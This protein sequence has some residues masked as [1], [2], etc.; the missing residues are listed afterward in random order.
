MNAPPSRELFRRVRTAATIVAS[1]AVVAPWPRATAH[2]LGLSSIDHFAEL[3]IGPDR[4]RVRYLL[5]YAEFAAAPELDLIDANRDDEVAPEERE[6]YL[7]A[8]TKRVVDHLRL[9]IDGA[10]VPLT[11]SWRRIAFPPGEAGHSTVRL[12]WELLATGPVAAQDSHFLVWNDANHEAQEGWKEIR[13]RGTGGIGI[14]STSLRWNGSLTEDGD[15]P[16]ELLSNPLNDTKAWC[17]FGV[18]LEPVAGQDTIVT[19]TRPDRA[20]SASRGTRAPRR[21]IA[22]VLVAGALL[23][24]AVARRAPSERA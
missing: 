24:F 23:A 20:Q 22:S 21:M 2:T 8:K 14:G 19:L 15:Y 4:V 7:D 1:L 16:P 12:T 9:E 5:D 13:F 11:V 6:S 18:G 10:D 17:R 3:E